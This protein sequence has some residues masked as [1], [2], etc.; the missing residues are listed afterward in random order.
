MVIGLTKMVVML[1]LLTMVGGTSLAITNPSHTLAT[2][3][4]GPAT[5][6]LKVSSATIE[7]V[8][9]LFRGVAAHERSIVSQ[10]LRWMKGI[11]GLEKIPEVIIPTNDMASFPSKEYPLFPDYLETKTSEY[12]YTI[13]S[14]GALT[15][16]VP[17]TTTSNLLETIEESLARLKEEGLLDQ[18]EE[19]K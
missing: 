3:F 12:K 19:G 17:E 7:M 6:V 11:E 16:H 9:G 1:S 5:A 8:N 18:L 4:K 2:P 14:N 15:V 13:D 10:A